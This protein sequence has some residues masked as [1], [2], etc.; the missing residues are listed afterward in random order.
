MRGQTGTPILR[1]RQPH[2]ATEGEEAFREMEMDAIRTLCSS[3]PLV[4][5]TGGG[6]V[7]NSVNVTRLRRNGLV[8]LL[9]SEPEDIAGRVRDLTRRP[10]LA[11]AENPQARIRELL[12]QREPA[13]RAAAHVVVETGEMSRDETADRVVSIYQDHCSGRRSVR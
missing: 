8:V 13:Y 6:A 2:R 1:Q 11:G 9:W 5:S 10:L 7:L 12:A 3:P 4:L